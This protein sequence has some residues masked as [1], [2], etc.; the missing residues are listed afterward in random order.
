MNEVYVG[1]LVLGI[2]PMLI[3]IGVVIYLYFKND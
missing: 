2:I 1:L 3:A